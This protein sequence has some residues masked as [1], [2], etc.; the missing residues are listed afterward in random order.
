MKNVLVITEPFSD[1]LRWD[2]QNKESIKYGFCGVSEGVDE[3]RFLLRGALIPGDKDYERRSFASA[4]TKGDLVYKVYDKAC[5]DGL[6]AL[7][8]VHTH[9]QRSFFSSKDERDAETHLRILPDFDMEFYLRLVVG[10]EEV[11]AIV[12]RLENGEWHREII[13][14]ILVY[15]R[16]GIDV[17]IPKNSHFEPGS[18]IDENLH[19]RTLQIGGGIE[20]ALKLT[21]F[22]KIGVIATGGI[23]AAF[24]NTCKFLGFGR[25]TLID[26][27]ILERSNAN[28]F[29]GYHAGDEGKPKV[30]VIKRELL[31]FN[32]DMEIETFQEAF[33]SENTEKALKSCDIIVTAPDHHWVRIQAAG[34]AATHL[35]PLFSGGAG[36]YAD[37]DG[38]PYRISC[39]TWFQPPPPLGPCL[40]CLGIK[41]ELPPKYEKIVYEARR[42]YIKGLRDPGPTP[43]SVVT[44]H[45]QCANLLVRHILF[46]LSHISDTPV[47]LHLVYDEIPL[48]FEDLTSLFTQREECTICGKSAF[49]AYGDYAPRIPSKQEMQEEI[50]AEAP[51][52]HNHSEVR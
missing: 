43:A 20:E 14:Y 29:I 2:F 40:R 25:F 8:F 36:I 19:N 48:R 49:W 39:S 12:H 26:P 24:I 32:P 30:E 28:R 5:K 16:S 47:P 42:S 3:R 10:K 17:I 15:K 45:N 38:N 33:P 27:D 34:F 41:A 35:K 50:E 46:Y 1:L 44:L 9:P 21:G 11:T 37:E 4:S 13:D 22:L 23:G 18:V 31:A 52:L 51:L 6:G 7:L